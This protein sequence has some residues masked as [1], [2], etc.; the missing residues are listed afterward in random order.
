M[1]EGSGITQILDLSRFDPHRIADLEKFRQPVTIVFTDIKGSTAYFEKYGDAAGLAMVDRCNRILTETLEQ[2]HGRLIKTIGDSIMGQFTDGPQSVTAAIEMQRRLTKFNSSLPQEGRICVRVGLHHGTG[3]VRSQ[4]VFGDVVNVASRVESVAAPEQIVISDTLYEQVKDANF[5]IVY[6]GRFALK[7]KKEERDLYEVIWNDAR[8]EQAA[9]AAHLMV[10]TADGGARRRLLKLEHILHG[11]AVGKSYAIKPEGFTIGRSA[12]DVQCP[13]D[14]MDRLQARF[15]VVEGQLF[16]EDL[17]HSGMVFVRLVGTYPL[18]QGDE[19]ILGRQRFRFSARS[20]VISAAAAVG[21]DLPEI[22]ANG[23]VAEFIHLNKDGTPRQSFPL[24][25]DEIVW[26]RMSGLY[27]FPD[28]RLMSRQH[29]KVY[30]RGEDF[31]LEDLG[32]RNGSFLRVRDKTP[33]PVGASV[34]VGAQL[35]RVVEQ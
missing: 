24:A 18:R 9:P 32:S 6:L 5:N 12:G 17:T 13:E 30:H 19:V 15:S 22:S 8:G 23:A 25:K 27:T 4:D 1:A 26:G 33:V 16:L 21:A 10:A 7:G 20:D 28:D 35:F 31:F 34:L 14:G 2:H 3:I 29:A 11:G